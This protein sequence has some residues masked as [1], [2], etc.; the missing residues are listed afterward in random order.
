MAIYEHVLLEGK[1]KALGKLGKALDDS[2]AVTVAVNHRIC[3]R[4]PDHCCTS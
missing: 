3:T 2:V 1:R 4:R